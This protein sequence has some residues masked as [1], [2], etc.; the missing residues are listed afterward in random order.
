MSV[1]RVEYSCGVFWLVYVGSIFVGAYVGC[2]C[3]VRIWVIW[4]MVIMWETRKTAW[5]R[6][7]WTMAVCGDVVV[8]PS[9]TR[10]ETQ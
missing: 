3:R 7:L 10:C 1:F 8:R 5:L 6:G 2:L 4:C 9:E